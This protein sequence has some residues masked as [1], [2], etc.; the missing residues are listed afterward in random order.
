MD[1]TSL[2]SRFD[3]DDERHRKR[4]TNRDHSARGGTRDRARSAHR[5]NGCAA[6]ARVKRRTRR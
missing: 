3:E 6:S 4:D 2:S 1:L 5:K